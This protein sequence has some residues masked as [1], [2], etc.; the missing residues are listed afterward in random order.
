MLLRFE[1]IYHRNKGK[2]K[3]KTAHVLIIP[4]VVTNSSLILL[5]QYK[6]VPFGGLMFTFDIHGILEIFT[7][8]QL[9]A[10]HCLLGS[11]LTYLQSWKRHSDHS[12]FMLTFYL[13]QKLHLVS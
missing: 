1:D 10:F 12:D 8:F 5:L 2:Q 7:A 3:F 11:T 4:D 13:K 9:G 6:R